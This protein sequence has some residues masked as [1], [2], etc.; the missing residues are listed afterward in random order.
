MTRILRGV[1]I[2]TPSSPFHGPGLEAFS[3][4]GLVIQEGRIVAA[5]AFAEVRGQYPDAEVSDLR[6]GVILPGFVDLHVHYPQA[7]IIGAL[8]YRLLDWL[9][10]NTLPEEARLADV[11][12]A[13]AL[14]KDFLR[15][16]LNN[17]TTTALVFGSHFAAAM[18]VFFEEALASGLRILSGL[19]L[20]DRNLRPEL[21]T[22]PQR[23]Y[24]ESL[25]LAQKWHERGKLRYVVTPRFSLSC[26]EAILE[27]CQQIQKELPGVF[28]T[29]HLNETPEEIAAVKRLFPWAES[30][31]QTYDRF[32]LVNQRAVLAH[33]VYPQDAELECLASREAAVAHCPCSNAFIGSGI[34]PLRRH[35]E[36]GVKFALGTDVAGGTGFGIPKEALMAYLAQRLLPEGHL[37]TAPQ[38]LYLATRAGAEA[39]GLQ[40]EIG[41]FGIGKAADLVYV[42][43]PKG[44]SLEAVLRHAETPEQAL[45]ALFTMASE[46]DIAQVYVD[47]KER[48]EGSSPDLC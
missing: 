39:L 6:E 34:F 25:W 19:V 42:K 29:S 22:T 36:A 33:N 8:G 17:G 1:L 4:G 26:S 35:L 11:T 46:A 16:L 20:S 7:R 32:G 47:G 18:E 28:F 31:C 5:G 45:G 2:H 13:R 9:E 12:Y 30:Y 23:A 10:V 41:D 24:R 27:V 15:G 44:S 40:G 43:P 38:L 48:L 21:H 14:A 37:L 3:D